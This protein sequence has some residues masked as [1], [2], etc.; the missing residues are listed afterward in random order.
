MGKGLIFLF[1]V[2][3]VVNAFA[4]SSRATYAEVLN[5]DEELRRNF[6][7]TYRQ[8]RADFRS[9]FDIGS[10]TYVP[11]NSSN[12]S[13]LGTRIS[14]SL[15]GSDLERK[16]LTALAKCNEMPQK[17]MPSARYNTKAR[18]K[19]ACRNLSRIDNDLASCQEGFPNKW[20]GKGLDEFEKHSNTA[21]EWYGSRAQDEY[22]VKLGELDSAVD[23]IK[24][25]CVE[26]AVSLGQ[27][28]PEVNSDKGEVI[29]LGTIT[30]VT[31]VNE[32]YSVNRD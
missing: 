21:S 23:A 25:H 14:S 27:N 4:G 26:A 12:E 6:E 20:F 7:A 31:D 10:G 15:R 30:I 17:N 8:R 5:V 28:R 11:F 32:D 1:S 3:L 22:F 19:R 13:Q 9:V 29:D 16:F 24:D 2:L 18:F